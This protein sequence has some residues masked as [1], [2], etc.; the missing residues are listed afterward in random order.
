MVRR[1]N[2]PRQ[3][4]WREKLT[5][6]ERYTIASDLTDA[7][8]TNIKFK[9]PLFNGK[10]TVF[11]Q[12]SKHSL[13]TFRNNLFSGARLLVLGDSV[14]FYE[15]VQEMGF[16]TNSPIFHRDVEKLDRQDDC[17]ASRLFSA[18]SLKWMTDRHPEWRL[19]L[20]CTYLFL[21]SWW[22]HTRTVVFR[23]SNGV[24]MVLRARHFLDIWKE[25]L[26]EGRVQKGKTLH[27]SR[28]G[29][30]CALYH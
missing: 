29:E 8:S 12:D 2:A 21:A 10:P 15:M 24:K 11:V 14:A 4:N 28:G 6:I 1:Q 19:A 25:F 5:R 23:T 17:A 27:F 18:S 30:Y 20:S 9:I 16:D 7:G 3:S 22:M 13:K 26:N